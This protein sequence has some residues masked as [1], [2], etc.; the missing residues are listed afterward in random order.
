[1]HVL[2]TATVALLFFDLQS[3]KITFAAE[4]IST[5]ST[6]FFLSLFVSVANL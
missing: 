6:D 4:T 1:M 5:L 2:L 3:Q